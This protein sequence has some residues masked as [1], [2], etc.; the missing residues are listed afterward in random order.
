MTSLDKTDLHLAAHFQ[1]QTIQSVQSIYD[2]SSPMLRELQLT[3]TP[4]LESTMTIV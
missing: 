2:L 4:I 1:N 3:W